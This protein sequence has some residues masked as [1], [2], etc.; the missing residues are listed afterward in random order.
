MG[1]LEGIEDDDEIRKRR[2]ELISKALEDWR[3]HYQ[4]V[5]YNEQFRNSQ[6]FRL[7]KLKQIKELTEQSLNVTV[8]I[9]DKDTG[10]RTF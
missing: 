3:G 8:A 5:I 9:I 2:G 10:E 4:H 7:W 6:E 1:M